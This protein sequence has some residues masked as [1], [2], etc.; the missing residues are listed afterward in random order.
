MESASPG[1]LRPACAARRSRQC[2][3]RHAIE[4]SDEHDGDEHI[5][6]MNRVMS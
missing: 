6:T 3:S 4:A 5:A 2:R 1:L